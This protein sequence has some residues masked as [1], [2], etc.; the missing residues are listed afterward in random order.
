MGSQQKLSI[1]CPE[2]TG[3][4]VKEKQ[5]V[6][7]ECSSPYGDFRWHGSVAEIKREIRRRWP[8]VTD[9]EQV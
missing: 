2:G 5:D 9:I 7:W 3:E 6:P 1:Q 4:A 8:D